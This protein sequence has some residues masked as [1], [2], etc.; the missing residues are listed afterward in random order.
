L[1]DGYAKNV[2]YKAGVSHLFEQREFKKTY[3]CGRLSDKRNF[4]AENQASSH[5]TGELFLH[6]SVLFALSSLNIHIICSRSRFE[7]YVEGE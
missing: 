4:A 6:T 3:E 1:V 2:I 5:P 7:S